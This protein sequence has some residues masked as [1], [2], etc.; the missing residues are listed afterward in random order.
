MQ[1]LAS[2]YPQV[3]QPSVG[4]RRPEPVQGQEIDSLIRQVLGHLTVK[5][6]LSPRVNDTQHGNEWAD[7]EPVRGNHWHGHQLA[8]L[9]WTAGLLAASP[10]RLSSVLVDHLG[11]HEPLLAGEVV[12]ALGGLD[13]DDREGRT[14]DT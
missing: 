14:A 3:A 10:R 5:P 2:R 12:G 4:I 11:A 8:R 9:L 13:Y 7:A 1:Q 6:G